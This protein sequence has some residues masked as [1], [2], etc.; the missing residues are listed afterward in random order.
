MNSER[1]ENSRS[2]RRLERLDPSAIRPQV[3]RREQDNSTILPVPEEV[4]A[5]PK[6]RRIGHHGLEGRD[7]QVTEV[8]FSNDLARSRGRY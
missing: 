7:A 1:S 2:K 3:P 8:S 5:E 4:I 6:A